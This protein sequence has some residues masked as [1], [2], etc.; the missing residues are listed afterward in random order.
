MLLLIDENE[1]GQ[2]NELNINIQ[3]N[4]I[5]YICIETIQSISFCNANEHSNIINI[6]AERNGF[7]TPHN[8]TCSQT[9]T[10]SN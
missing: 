8:P 4:T 9:G 5:Q 3:Y 6:R 1:A 10:A 7:N 2:M